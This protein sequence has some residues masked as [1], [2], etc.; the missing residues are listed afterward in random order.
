MF[1]DCF[2]SV[3]RKGVRRREGS[4]GR[5][6]FGMFFGEEK[7][8]GGERGVFCFCFFCVFFGEEE[9]VVCFFVCVCFLLKFLWA[10]G[11]EAS[12]LFLFGE[13]GGRVGGRG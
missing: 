4:G 12:G 6:L 5:V 11:G 2:R 13:R 8:R 3:C 10:G 7:E 1:L 9:G